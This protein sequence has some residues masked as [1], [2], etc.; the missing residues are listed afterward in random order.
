ML[1]PLF[2]ILLVGAPLIIHEG[3]RLADLHA[4][5]TQ[6]WI[7]NA[8]LLQNPICAADARYS[9]GAKV[10]DACRAAK[11]E[12]AISPEACAFRELWRQG[13][14]YRVW[15]SV[16]S[17]PWMLFGLLGGSL[18]LLFQAWQ[19]RAQRAQQ[20][21]MYERHMELVA[22]VRAPLSP[23]PPPIQF[24]MPAQQPEPPRALHY[25]YDERQPRLGGPRSVLDL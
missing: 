13:A 23:S 2:L 14:P 22:S 21:R 19:Y 10:E 6:R 3:L 24:I 16:I 4:Q 11:A 18:F 9:H 8:M 25:E 5:C 17:S 15:D 1:A 12:N 20:E 7:E